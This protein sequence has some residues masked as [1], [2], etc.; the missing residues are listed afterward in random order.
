MIVQQHA[1]PPQTGLRFYYN[2]NCFIFIYLL[3]NFLCVIGVFRNTAEIDEKNKETAEERLRSVP[4][5][6]SVC[7][8]LADSN[9]LLEPCHHKVACE[10]CSALMKKCIQ[11]GSHINKR[12]TQGNKTTNTSHFRHM[13]KEQYLHQYN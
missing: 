9:V 1:C 12:S 3:E 13:L 4:V 8:E 6:C 10:E 5:E 7:S 11:C 2:V